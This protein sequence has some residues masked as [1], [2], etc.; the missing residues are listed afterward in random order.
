MKNS[1]IPTLAR[2]VARRIAREAGVKSED[3]YTIKK[4]RSRHHWINEHIADF[5]RS[6]G[7]WY[8]GAFPLEESNAKK[9]VLLLTTLQSYVEEKNLALVVYKLDSRHFD[10]DLITFPLTITQHAI[11]RISQRMK[12]GEPADIAATL[13]P[14]MK[15]I[16]FLE[17]L[18]D[19]GM[20]LFVPTTTGVL[21]GH[22]EDGK[23]ILKTFVAD[24]QLRPEQLQHKKELMA[25]A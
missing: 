3:P 20:E 21:L 6:T 13:V 23:C 16:L 2:G 5:K 15:H 17:S 18:P 11:E 10:I 8:I 22:M 9:P 14:A 12:S 24:H 1:P 4:T 25:G 19:D 7:D